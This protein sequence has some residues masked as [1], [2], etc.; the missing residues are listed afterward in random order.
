MSFFFLRNFGIIIEQ[1][2]LVLLY[3]SKEEK[4]LNLNKLIY[5]KN[6]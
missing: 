2:I 4:F 6:K 3:K 1:I 5:F